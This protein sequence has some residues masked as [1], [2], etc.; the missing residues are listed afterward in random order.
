MFCS[1]FSELNVRFD[2]LISIWTD[3]PLIEVTIKGLGEHINSVKV[4]AD[5]EEKV[6]YW[7]CRS[8]ANSVG[9]T[10]SHHLLVNKKRLQ[11]KTIHI[12]L[13]IIFSDSFFDRIQV[14]EAVTFTF[15]SG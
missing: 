11:N 15:I 10:R 12:F 6:V 9:C 14:S 13:I 1:I 4:L 7:F 2:S 8:L 3:P 5:L